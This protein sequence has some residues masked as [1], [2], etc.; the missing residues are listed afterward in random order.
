MKMIKVKIGTIT[1][2]RNLKPSNKTEKCD[3]SIYICI[4]FRC[5]HIKITIMFIVALFKIVKN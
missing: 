1:L 3:I 4:N 5:M 2:E